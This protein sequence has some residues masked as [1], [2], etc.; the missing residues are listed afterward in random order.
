MPLSGDTAAAP[1]SFD[2]IP[3]CIYIRR[4]WTLN[5]NGFIWLL[6]N[7]FSERFPSWGCYVSISRFCVE[8]LL[9]RVLFGENPLQHRCE[10]R[11]DDGRLIQS[12][13]LREQGNV[14]HHFMKAAARNGKKR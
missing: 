9:D 13:L 6:I 7:L 8:R 12:F 14:S 3:I 5:Y 1:I 2:T 11:R 4:A 10:S